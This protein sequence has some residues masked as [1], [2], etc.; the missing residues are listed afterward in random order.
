MAEAKLTITTNAPQVAEEL[1]QVDS[2][3]K[4][5]TKSQK[6]M[7]D[8][9]EI[10]AKSYGNVATSIR[11]TQKAQQELST[12]TEK[13]LKRENGLIE[14][15]EQSIKELEDSRRKAWKVEDIEKY[16]QKI[17]T[18]KREM[19][20]YETVG[21]KAN[22]NIAKSTDKLGGALDGAVK[23]FG[24][25]ALAI[26]AIT[27]VTKSMVEAFKDTVFGLNLM[28]TAGEV[29]HQL[30]YNLV[31]ANTLEGQIY[32]LLENKLKDLKNTTF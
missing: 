16:N 29:W 18:A 15:I 30:V 22:E 20:E 10:I 17:A 8:N 24:L 27:K 23:K 28:T 25:A 21:V 26:G 32:L 9:A 14:D 6:Y 1:K 12:E 3:I 13:G 7:F 4:N 19:K 5:I 2:E 11:D 31:A